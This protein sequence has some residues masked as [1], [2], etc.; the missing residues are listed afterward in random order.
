M[1]GFAGFVSFP[2]E[3]RPRD[4]RQSILQRM[5]RALAHRGPDDE[6]FYLDDH[7]SFVFRRLSIIDVAG[8]AQPI[9]NED[10]SMFVAV[11][12]E[13]YNYRELRRSLEGKHTFSTHSDSEVVLH[14][15]EEHG[16]AAFA[17]LNGMYS[18]V[19][20]NGKSKQLVLARD[21]FGIKPLY[22]A[23]VDSGVLFG[24]ELKG[25]LMHPRCPRELDWADLT[26][27]GLSQRSQVPSYVKD[28]HHLPA[29][30]YAA[31]SPN[32]PI[33]VRSYWRIEA[34]SSNKATA[35]RPADYVDEYEALLVDSVQRQLMSDVPIGLMLSGGIDSSLIAAIAAKTGAEFHCF[36]FAEENT[37]L[38]GDLQDSVNVTNT[39]NLPHH[40][41]YFD[42]TTL[43]AEIDF[44]LA[45]LEH[46]VWMMDSPR[47][48]LEFLFKHEIHRFVK[49]RYPAVK[50]LLLGQ[51]ADEFSGGYS[52]LDE[53]NYKDWDDYMARSVELGVRSAVAGDRG[54]PSRFVALLRDGQD[55]GARSFRDYDRRMENYYYQMQH[56][57]LWHEDRTSSSQGREA[58]VPF[59]DH[60]LVEFA[61]AVPQSLRRDLFWNKRIVR[62]VIARQLPS[63]PRGKKKIPFFVTAQRKSIEKFSAAILSKVYPAFEE[64]YLSEDDALFGQ[65][66]F[67]ALVERAQR[68]GGADEEAV[69]LAME[70]M[71]VQ[72]FVNQLAATA[73]QTAAPLPEL[74]RASP[75]LELT[76]EQRA[77]LGRCFVSNAQ[78]DDAGFEFVPGLRFA[79]ALPAD[80]ATT[81]LLVIKDDKVLGK[82]KLPGAQHWVTRWLGAPDALSR[83]W[84]IEQVASE[85]H[86]ALSAVEG[87]IAGLRERGYVQ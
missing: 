58:R 3:T 27:V 84:Q 12:G 65:A 13:I 77:E 79:S 37:Y 49:T 73:A 48:D 80:P 64:K 86:A 9:W 41:V 30:A 60:R 7:L 51:G 18:V 40:P 59:L 47:F 42:L 83:R 21:R 56:F 23:E 24:S 16:M 74:I 68:R 87:F 44:G 2:I 67:H 81:H 38:S 1:C 75:L 15:F 25:L 6:T 62:D 45:T 78:A 19:L 82:L 52:G 20:W 33:N 35:S 53:G 28:V 36:S 14:L 4:E 50:V 57:N 46:F 11:N 69:W 43:L 71:C 34:L 72:I 85:T 32:A 5:S 54:I 29:G 76:H 63:Y 66:E 39:L 10:K 26:A 22:Y 8:G 55:D 31:V 17:M 70:A 61:F